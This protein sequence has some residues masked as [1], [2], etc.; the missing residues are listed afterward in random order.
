[1]ELVADVVVILA[2][3]A[4]SREHFGF[5]SSVLT[6][7]VGGQEL[8]TWYLFDSGGFWYPGLIRIRRVLGCLRRTDIS[9]YV[10]ED[11]PELVEDA[12]PFCKVSTIPQGNP[13]T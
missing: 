8:R 6:Y 13:G 10:V 4:I 11:R 1:M 7:T 12:V 3:L 5:C 9:R 2:Y